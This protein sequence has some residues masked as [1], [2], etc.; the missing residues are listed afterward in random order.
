MRTTTTTNNND[1]DNNNNRFL[2]APSQA[3]T[4]KIFQPEHVKRKKVPWWCRG[5]NNP[6]TNMSALPWWTL[7]A[8]PRNRKWLI[9]PVIGR[10]NPLSPLG[11]SVTYDWDEPP[12]PFIKAN[13]LM[14][15][16]A[17]H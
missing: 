13:D 16:D 8:Y 9:V 4:P 6:T 7:M 5:F 15:R 1:N 10:L 11:W 17:H 3:Q 12:V 2:L 14:K